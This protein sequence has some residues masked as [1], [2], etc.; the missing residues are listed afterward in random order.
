MSATD[1]AVAET[2]PRQ[3]VGSPD[4][5]AGYDVARIRADFP[6]LAREVHDGRP[7]VFLDSAASA[8]KPRQVLDTMR[9][10]YE[11]EYANVHRGTY[12]LSERSTER[13]EAARDTARDFLNARD[14]REIVFT[15]NATEAINLVAYSWARTFLEP[16][17]EIL[18][19][20]M[21]HHSN[22]VPWQ[23]IR[24]ENDLVLKAAPVDDDGVFRI[25]NLAKLVTPKTRLIAVTHVSNV[26]GTVLPIR[27]LAKLAHDNNA[28][29]L[30]DGSQAVMHMPV[31]VQALDCDFYVFTGHK[32]YGPSGIGVLYAKEALLDAMPPFMG[33][34]DMISSVT[35]AE[36]RWA[37]PPAKF[38][39]GTPAIVQAVGL[40][41][42]LDYLT[43]AGIEAVSAHERNLGTYAAQRLASVDGLK[44]FGTAPDKTSVISF[45][46]DCAHPH[47][48]GTV[49][50]RAGVCIRA[51]HHCAQP[52]ME[53]FDTAAMARAS[54]GMYNTHAEI[55]TLVDALS[56]VREM[57]G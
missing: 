40:A 50:D 1:M 52:L 45:T 27:E 47:D 56:T 8:Q 10:F 19:T 49:I 44:I 36:S 20:V 34:G 12:L 41:A 24:D 48:I 39:A 51:G 9:D 33:G 30:V 3:D 4:P 18:T 32:I 6:I 11:T 17:D 26:L 16:G 57:F 31:D 29:L 35:I 43:E 2:A 13:Y 54:F 37:A 21:E 53:R 25:E 15:R 38:E 55:D 23:L 22:I 5:A 7:L 14:R 46:M 42:A 28:L